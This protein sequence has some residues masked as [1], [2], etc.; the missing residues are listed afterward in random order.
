MILFLQVLRFLWWRIFCISLWLNSI[1]FAQNSSDF[2]GQVTVLLRK[3]TPA[4]PSY[5]IVSPGTRG[6]IIY[7]GPVLSVLENN[8]SFTKTPD[9]SN[10]GDLQGPFQ[11]GVLGSLRARANSSI[12]SNG[13]I[14][15]LDITEHGSEYLGT[16]EIVLSPPH[17]GSDSSDNVFPA[18]AEAEID[19]L[20]GKVSNLHLL[21]AGRGYTTPPEI[22]I[23]GGPCFL[24]ITD[25]E[26][27]QSGL[28]FRVL[29]N[30]DDTLELENPLNLDL[31]ATIPLSTMVEVFQG[32]TLGSLLGYEEPII[33][34]DENSS[35]ADWV[36]IIKEPDQQGGVPELDYSAHFHDGSHWAKIDQPGVNSSDT[37]IAPGESII[38]AR[39]Q[40]SEI[41]LPL[42]GIANTQTSAWEIP[43]HGKRN[44]V[45]NPFPSAV[46]L[47]DLLRKESITEANTTE[48]STLWLAH[49]NQDFA[50]NLHILESSIWT[51]YWHDG[52]NLDVY[53]EAEIAVRRGSGTGGS[54]TSQDFSFSS[55]LIEDITNP[56]QDNIVVTSTNHGLKNGFLVTISG[57][58][59]KLTNESKVQI[60]ANYEEV[61][62][63][64]GL[65]VNSSANG[66]WEIT[67]CTPHTFELL[68]AA[69]NCDFNQNNQ[70]RWQ[71]GN[72]GQGYDTDVL[73]TIPGG[74]GN[75]ARAIG[76]VTNGQITEI[77]ISSGGL[78]YT[79][80]TKA[81]VHAGGW[82]S[83]SRGNAPLND[84]LIPAGSG[85]LLER[86][87]PYGVAN[88]LPLRPL[89][90]Q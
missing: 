50:D 9:L 67:N 72:P 69:N 38:L 62:T 1:L 40:N 13:S 56:A 83:I 52:S 81:K 64:F 29:R 46:M 33:Q 85:V 42:S 78:I 34:P 37:V 51:T 43:P 6:E 59:G 89:L 12:D 31:A 41:Q 17:Q 26:S 39:H 73:I 58:I 77:I 23:Q 80:P 79:S 66:Q 35:M 8:V 2:V 68:G 63:D 18:Y 70:A 60:N 86:K 15:S 47:S 3:G 87:H 30:T 90:K 25:P 71:T 16:P 20:T 57:V 75:D 36:Y 49:P 82:R 11:S 55:G 54:L 65:I 45:C 32:W 21:S 4:S 53:K 27:N 44:L 10:P 74:G 76:K 28:F 19:T 48:T 61:E 24:R 7:R 84:K 22:S 88:L 5:T 14:A